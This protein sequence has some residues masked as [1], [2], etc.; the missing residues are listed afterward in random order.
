MIFVQYILPYLVALLTAICSGLITYFSAIKKCKLDNDVK[1]KEIQE[2]HKLDLE[3]QK[4]MFKL[5]IDKI[6]LQHQNELEKLKVESN[7]QLTN[8]LANSFMSS[9]FTNPQSIENLIELANKLNKNK[10]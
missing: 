10:K 8:N 7:N 6:N 3:N 9:L 1:I 5:E 4:E 2:Q